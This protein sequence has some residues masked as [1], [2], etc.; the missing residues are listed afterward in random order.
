MK[1]VK[2]YLM[3]QGRFRHMS[4]EDIRKLQMWVCKKWNLHYMEKGRPEICE[5]ALPEE[6][7]AVTEEHREMHGP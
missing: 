3:M 1:S 7:H 2:D 6:H 4:D 5:I